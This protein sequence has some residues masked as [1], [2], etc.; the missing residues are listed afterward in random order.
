MTKKMT[1]KQLD[2]VISQ[3]FS[4]YSSHV[5]FPIMA[6]PKIY[7]E[8]RI[9]YQKASGD[10]LLAIDEAMKVAIKTYRVN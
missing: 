7:A 1:A 10:P 6:L 9:A 4:R 2:K 3:S 5:Q 8:C